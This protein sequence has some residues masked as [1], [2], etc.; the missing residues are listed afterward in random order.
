[1]VS[2]KGLKVMATTDPHITIESW[3]VMPNHIHFILAIQERTFSSNQPITLGNLIQ[4]FKYNTTKQ[5]NQIR[6]SPGV[7]IWH[8]N[9]YEH[10]I[11]NQQAHQKIQTYIHQN[12]RHWTTDK[13][14]LP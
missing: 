14:H 2:T 13:F 9:Y 6:N 10:I 3:V 12:P 7:K 4:Q 8:R 1:M 11:R 5:I